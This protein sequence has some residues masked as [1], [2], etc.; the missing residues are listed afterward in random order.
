MTGWYCLG[1]GGWVG[2]QEDVFGS[3]F[4][5]LVTIFLFAYLTKYK[6]RTWIFLCN[7]IGSW[8]FFCLFE[9]PTPPQESNGHFCAFL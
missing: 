4:L 9:I 6:T 1:G 8:I 7:R 3:N 2:G 5:N